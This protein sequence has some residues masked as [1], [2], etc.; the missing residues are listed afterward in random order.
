MKIMFDTSVLV[1]GM[2]EPHPAHNKALPWLKRA[3][4][5]EL[6]FFV[7]RHT[8]AEL[9]VV[10]TTL[11]VSPRIS[12]GAARSLIRENVEGSAK[13]IS[14]SAP[15][16][17]AVIRRV[18]DLGLSGGVVYDAMIARAAKKAQVDRLLTL[19]PEDFKRIWPDG[20][21]LITTP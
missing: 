7:A 12:P 14:L 3:R 13:T 19:N 11:P 5:G 2:V 15:D 16:Y 9:F 4:A 18:S 1:A 8:L 20:A 21:S 17:R 10:L 6:K